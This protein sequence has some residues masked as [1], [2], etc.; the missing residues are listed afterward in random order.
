MGVEKA[1]YGNFTRMR[2]EE[3]GCKE[4]QDQRELH[5]ETV[6]SKRLGLA[7]GKDRVLNLRQ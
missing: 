5:S 4:R 2:V 7:S 1:G 3:A 6:D